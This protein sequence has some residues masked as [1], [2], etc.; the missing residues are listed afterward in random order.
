MTKTERKKRTN[1]SKAT[2]NDEKASII[3]IKSH[4]IP[5]Q[6]NYL[7]KFKSIENVNCLKYVRIKK[8]TEEK[9]NKQTN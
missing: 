9:K 5:F 4:I 7:T 8:T 1:G 6:M 2:T 3:H